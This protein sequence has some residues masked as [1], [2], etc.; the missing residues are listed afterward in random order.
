MEMLGPSAY[1]LTSETRTK[2]WAVSSGR[3]Q[4]GSSLSDSEGSE[5][6]VTVLV[7][8]PLSVIISVLPTFF[9]NHQKCADLWLWKGYY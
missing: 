3:L 5:F 4:L 1:G 2:V 6:F 8:L 7:L 9:Y